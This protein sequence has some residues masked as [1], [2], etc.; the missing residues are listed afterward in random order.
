M[1]VAKASGDVHMRAC[2]HFTLAQAL[3][4]SGQANQA[5][6]VGHDMQSLYAGTDATG[7][8]CAVLCVSELQMSAGDQRASMLS[9]KNAIDILEA[10]NASVSYRALA[11]KVA[12]SAALTSTNTASEGFALADE[13]LNL[14][15]LS[16]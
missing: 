7:E 4:A 1:D 5:I 16:G 2:V 13:A 12:A 8:G 10:G 11:R 14:F 3:A 15:D 6:I 9:G